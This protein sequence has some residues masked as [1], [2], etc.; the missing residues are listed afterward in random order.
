[1]LVGFAR[2]AGR[3][4]GCVRRYWPMRHGA[5]RNRQRCDQ[6]APSGADSGFVM[7]IGSAVPPPQP[8][9]SRARRRLQIPQLRYIESAMLGKSLLSG[10]GVRP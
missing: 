6:A 2:Q 1:M 4:A 10:E 3:Q 5:R 9:G 7:A 8:S